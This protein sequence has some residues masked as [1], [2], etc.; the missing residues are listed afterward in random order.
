MVIF[1]YKINLKKTYK[2]LYDLSQS[3]LV[4]G[5]VY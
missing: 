3:S 5:L 4:M 2:S 1:L